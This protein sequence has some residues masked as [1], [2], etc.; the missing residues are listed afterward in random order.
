MENK[1]SPSQAKAI[2]S[3]ISEAFDAQI[4]TGQQ[5]PPNEINTLVLDLSVAR[6]RSNAREISFP[7]T[8]IYIEDA[9]DINTQVQIIPYAKDEIQQDVTMKKNDSFV[10]NNGVSKVFLTWPAQAG[11]KIVLK[12]F[13]SSKFTSGSLIIDQLSVPSN[14][15]MGFGRSDLDGFTRQIK[16]R[17]EYGNGGMRIINDIE[18]AQANN[19]AF[20][21][22]ATPLT[23]IWKVPAG[24]YAELIGLQ[25]KILTAL[26]AG[27][28]IYLGAI[29]N[30][31]SVTDGSLGITN[32]IGFVF[33]SANVAGD[34]NVRTEVLNQP[35]SKGYIRRGLILNEGEIPVLLN[36]GGAIAAGTFTAYL[37]F[38]L[39]PVVG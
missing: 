32:T 10:F 12:F 37:L 4:T 27:G 33:D 17:Y 16:M 13:V 28:E 1:L 22:G 36:G 20:T 2:V 26:T 7:M 18:D 9:T 21:M 29:P 3:A 35:T 15:E 5:N 24:Y 14:V 31:G 19:G 38:R 11:K 34:Y 23:Y 39:K 30:G 25:L 8:S 6:D